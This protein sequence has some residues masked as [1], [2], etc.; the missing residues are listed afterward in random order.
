MP[1]RWVCLDVGET[2]FDERH[3]WGRWADW[4]GVPR[5]ALLSEL[6]AVVR[7]GEGH[8]R[9]FERFR[10]GFDADAAT[11]E[12][13]AAGDDPGFRDEDLFADV[14]PS[15]AAL[16]DGGLRIGV[17]GN[18]SLLAERA[19]ERCGL[20]VAFVA[21][22]VRWG[23]AKPD[24]GFFARLAETCGA[25]PAEIAYV[26]DRI[27]NDVRPAE[28]AGMTGVWLRRGTWA[29]VHR[30]LPEAVRVRHAVDGLDGLPA[31]ILSCQ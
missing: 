25:P 12:R 20:P 28:R 16:H 15:L 13:L 22:A 5:P 21:S 29:R 19:V 27:D 11:A 18:T 3:Y 26:G 24:P 30:E 23:V 4:L 9:V 31:L 17:V 2:L 10:A 7:R 14:R 8:R 1:I 6:E